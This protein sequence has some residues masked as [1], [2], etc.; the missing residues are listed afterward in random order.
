MPNKIDP[1]AN[2]E[3]RTRRNWQRLARIV[4]SLG[5]GGVSGE[6]PSGTVNG[7]NTAFTLAATP[8]TGSVKVYLNGLRQT[9]TTDYTVSGSTITFVTAPLTGDI[10]RVDYDAA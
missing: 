7:S 1:N 6:T 4:D 8:A 10:I 9:L 2:S 3:L 5:N